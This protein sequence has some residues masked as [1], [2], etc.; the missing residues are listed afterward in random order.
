MPLHIFNSDKVPSNRWLQLLTEDGERN[1][2]IPAAKSMDKHVDEH[3]CSGFCHNN[4]WSYCLDLGGTIRSIQTVLQESCKPLFS[5]VLYTIDIAFP[6]YALT[7][8]RLGSNSPI[9]TTQSSLW[10]LGSH[11]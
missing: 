3:D 6:L 9:P 5:A 1:I 4:S 11:G 10:E 2:D 7:H 8:A